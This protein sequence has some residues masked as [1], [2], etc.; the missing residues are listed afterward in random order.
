MSLVRATASWCL[1]KDA[2]DMLSFK[3]KNEETICLGIVRGPGNQQEDHPLFMEEV[4][5]CH[6]SVANLP[7]RMDGPYGIY[8]FM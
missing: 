7:P 8:M 5:W 3:A 6:S 4:C 1:S 2:V